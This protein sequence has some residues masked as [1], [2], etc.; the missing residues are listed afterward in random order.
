MVRQVRRNRGRVQRWNEL[1]IQPGREGASAPRCHNGLGFC[2]CM[3]VQHGG[4][5]APSP[6]VPLATASPVVSSSSCCRGFIKKSTSY[7]SPAQ[8][9]EEHRYGMP[10]SS[11]GC[12]VNLVLVACIECGKTEMDC[13]GST[14]LIKMCA[15]RWPHQVVNL[16][17]VAC[18]EWGTADKDCHGF[19]RPTN[20][21]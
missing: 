1:R 6:P 16:V 13:H 4:R 11:K 3:W 2:N 10:R 5:A 7:L 21:V 14:C 19:T 17:L 15:M 12:R 9:M 20:D 8:R 18:T